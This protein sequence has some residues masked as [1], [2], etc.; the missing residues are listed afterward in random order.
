IFG[1]SFLGFFVNDA[2]TVEAGKAILDPF[3]W[4]LPFIGPQITLMVSFQAFG[5]PLQA[6]V[7]TLGRQLLFFI[8]LLYLLNHLF[9][10][11]GFVW[12]QPAAE[13]LNTG[14]AILMGLSLIKLMRGDGTHAPL[15]TRHPPTSFAAWFRRWLS[16]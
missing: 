6:M 15:I 14:T 3:L 4:A 7:I 10:F 5:K 13:M 11:R 1:D 16:K 2:K 8:P 9:G 12:A